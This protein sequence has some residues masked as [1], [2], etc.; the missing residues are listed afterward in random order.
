[1]D[2]VP[3]HRAGQRRRVVEPRHG[4]AGSQAVRVGV[5]HN[6]ANGARGTEG[7]SQREG[8]RMRVSVHAVCEIDTPLWNFDI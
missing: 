8:E 1:M 7:A 2:G 5:E 3:G 4:A 6:C